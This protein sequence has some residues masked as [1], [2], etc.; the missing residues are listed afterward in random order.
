MESTFITLTFKTY[1][2]VR[3]KVIKFTPNFL[4][5]DCIFYAIRHSRNQAEELLT[6]PQADA[7]NQD[8]KFGAL[9]EDFKMWKILVRIGNAIYKLLRGEFFYNQLSNENPN[10]FT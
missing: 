6:S 9:S 10:I 4:C 5:R 1:T 8:F 7:L 2:L 3:M